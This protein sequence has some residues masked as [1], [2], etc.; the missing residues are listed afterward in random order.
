MKRLTGKTFL[1]TRPQQ[2]NAELIAAIEK[3]G[4]ACYLLPCLNIKKLNFKEYKNNY[5]IC[6]VTSANAVHNFKIKTPATWIAIGPAT[7]TALQKQTIQ[8]V[9]PDCYNS[10]GLLEL[11]ILQSIENK[12]IAIFTGKNP[13]PLL[14]ETLQQRG[15]AVDLIYCYERSC[16]KYL[17]TDIKPITQ[18]SF[19]GIIACSNETLTNL[20][21]IFKDHTP[22]LIKQ[23]LI[24][25]SE[26]MR[27]R[28]KQIDFITIYQAI[29][30]SVASILECL[31]AIGK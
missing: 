30:S 31:L 5:D 4:G 24:V 9:I 17:K 6:I 26:S 21:T 29:D 23:P 1:I 20:C 15:A 10:E 14:H 8:T 22:W 2:Q 27:T 3:L 11:P 18:K 28:A 12:K 16:P 7:A 13:K 19:D 25:I